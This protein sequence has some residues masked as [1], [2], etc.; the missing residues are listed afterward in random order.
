MGEKGQ[1][2]WNGGENFADAA[3]PRK[4]SGG[5]FGEDA[6]ESVSFFS[7]LCEGE[8]DLRR[9]GKREEK[10]GFSNFAF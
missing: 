10:V 1:Q 4:C 9:E 8:E 3:Y 6:A 2:R 7:T 5:G